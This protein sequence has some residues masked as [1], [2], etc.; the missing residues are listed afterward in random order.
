MEKLLGKSLLLSLF[1]AT[2]PLSANSQDA[3]SSRTGPVPAGTIPMGTIPTGDG[4][5][6]NAPVPTS[7]QTPS[8]ES[9]G[10]IE[11]DRIRGLADRD[12]AQ[13]HIATL[14]MWKDREGSRDAVQQA[15][16]D[17]DPEISG[18]AKWILR[19]WRRGALPD[20]PP[21][22]SRLL[23]SSDSP[24]AIE[25]LLNRG[26]FQAAV[27]A[28]EESAGTI[29]RETISRR[30]TVALLQRFPLYAKLAYDTGSTETL[31]QLLDM[32]TDSDE[33]ALCRIRLMQLIEVPI[34]DSNLLPSSSSMWTESE[35][36]QRR[37][38]LLASLGQLDQALTLAEKEIEDSHRINT[39]S[40]AGRWDEICDATHALALQSEPNSYEHAIRWCDTLVAA[41]RSH[42][43]TLVDEAVRE[44]LRVDPESAEA[45]RTLNVRWKC[46]AIHGKIDEAI[47][48]FPESAQIQKSKLCL[49]AARPEMAFEMLG[50]PLAEI[51]SQLHHWIDSAIEEQTKVKTANLCEPVEKLL[52]LMRLLV[53]TGNNDAGWLIAKRLSEL[54]AGAD[55]FRV[56]DQML[57]ELT[58]TRNGD[59]IRQLAYDEN[60]DKLSRAS[61]ILLSTTLENVS[62]A[63]FEII[64]E[65]LVA[66]FP[67]WSMDQRVT[68]V[69]SLLEGDLPPDFDSTVDI[70]RL[71]SFVVTPR[72]NR[73]AGMRMIRQQMARGAPLPLS[74]RANLEIVQMFW[75]LGQSNAATSCL[76]A[77]AE[78]GDSDAVVEVAERAL[79][80]GD[81]DLAEE[82]YESILNNLFRVDSSTG[83][84]AS[85]SNISVAGKAMVGL[86]AIARRRGDEAGEIKREQQL[87]FMLCGPSESF[88]DDVAGYLTE[89][90]EVEWVQDI[91]QSGLAMHLFASGDEIRLYNAA[92][93]YA[94]ITSDQSPGESARWFDLAM[95]RLITSEDFRDS[96][97][98][99][100]PIYVHRWALEAAIKE[101][102]ADEVRRTIDV[103]LSLDP[104]D[105][106]LAERL[107]PLMRESGMGS[108]AS[109]T[110]KQILQ[111]GAEQV[112]KFPLD[113]MT[114]NNL[115]WVAAK[116]DHNLPL[117]RRL[118]RQAVDLE[119][120][121]SIY[122]DTLAEVL[123]RMDKPDQALAIEK[124]AI[125]DDPDQ[126]HLHQQIERFRVSSP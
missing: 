50:F 25:R 15:A 91:Y 67:H 73:L 105:I 114:C 109:E 37:I 117:A 97:F 31:L 23:R 76:N 83:V 90:G 36:R 4:K 8:Q 43:D 11:E 26:Q 64:Y 16:R 21:E 65:A 81:L 61:M 110:L 82:I 5:S 30:I 2:L 13:R 40:L 19:Q 66:M 80:A 51:D 59:W 52:V 56:R 87:R 75:R 123:Y 124:Q 10:E 122:L 103:L 1:F 98:V 74:I 44:L 68:S 47:R 104:V 69:I 121:S 106:D 34:D 94:M 22:I 60:E 62:E 41:S 84:I 78:S 116:N 113:A 99:A 12:Y 112:S 115:A 85:Q 32:V 18:R 9:V 89:L 49:H 42:R 14:E 53:A 46:L 107:L 20:T 111:Q 27:V 17:S 45:A 35:R 39:L 70:N 95:T 96:A 7:E 54:P 100:L 108:I 120:A 77:L 92:R 58:D 119:P 102:D 24:G 48:C 126:W 28:V 3:G 55:N 33:L 118:S 29:N 125:M 79:H 71:L 88:N 93:G 38:M 86:L 63:T 6:L 72:V 101:K 57:S